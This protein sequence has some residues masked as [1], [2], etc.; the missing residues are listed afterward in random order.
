MFAKLEISF[1][2]GENLFDGE[3]YIHQCFL[4]LGSIAVIHN[5]IFYQLNVLLE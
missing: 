1:L 4:V 3:V 2:R 5:K